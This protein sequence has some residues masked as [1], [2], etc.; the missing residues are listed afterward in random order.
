MEQ[1]EGKITS[2]LD[3]LK[4]KIDLMTKVGHL[5]VCV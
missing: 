1:L 4:E 5:L 2:E 3:S